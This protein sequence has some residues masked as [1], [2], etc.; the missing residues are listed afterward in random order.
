LSHAVGLCSLRREVLATLKAKLVKM[1]TRKKESAASGKKSRKRR[2]WAPPPFVVIGGN[3]QSRAEVAHIIA[4]HWPV[5][6]PRTPAEMPADAIGAVSIGKNKRSPYPSSHLYTDARSLASYM[7]Y[8]L[9]YYHTRHA[10]LSAAIAAEAAEKKLSLR[11]VELYAL[12]ATEMKHHQI[13]RVLGV[14]INTLKTR[15]RLLAAALGAPRGVGHAAYK[16]ALA[17]L[18]HPP[19]PVV[20]EH[21]LQ[22][23]TRKPVLSESSSA[24]GRRAK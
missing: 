1:P 5:V 17:A 4:S 7:V 16:L 21:L 19:K 15:M 23:R 14:S 18:A 20:P 3:E 24:R 13:I 9:A 11:Q 22:K 2:A 8:A 12:G 10:Q 6:A